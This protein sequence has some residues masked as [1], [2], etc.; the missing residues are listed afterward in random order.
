MCFW[1]QEAAEEASRCRQCSTLNLFTVKPKAT[2]I[3]HQRLTVVT[4][5]IRFELSNAVI[6][7]MS[8]HTAVHRGSVRACRDTHLLMLCHSWRAVST[9]ERGFAAWFPWRPVRRSRSLDPGP[10]E[11]SAFLHVW[12]HNNGMKPAPVYT[13][14]NNK[15]WANWTRLLSSVILTMFLFQAAINGSKGNRKCDAQ[16]CRGCY[17]SHIDFKMF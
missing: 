13:T 6:H 1:S 17:H 4:G 10:P 11:L 12:C 3:S 2:G 14:A 8:T 15:M 5:K 7:L 9:V 16:S